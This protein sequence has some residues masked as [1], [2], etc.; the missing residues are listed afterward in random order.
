MPKCQKRPFHELECC[1]SKRE[2]NL[3]VVCLGADL[4]TIQI[5]DLMYLLKEFIK[6]TFC[7]LFI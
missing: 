5:L 6:S 7:A 1:S 3:N 2:S 4:I